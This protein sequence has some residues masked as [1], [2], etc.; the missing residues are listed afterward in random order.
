[1]L[2][3]CSSLSTQIFWQGR[4][5]RWQSSHSVERSMAAGIEERQGRQDLPNSTKYSHLLEYCGIMTKERYGPNLPLWTR[6]LGWFLEPAI[7]HG[8]W[9]P[10][11]QTECSDLQRK[12]HH[13]FTIIAQKL[14]VYCGICTC[15]LD[16]KARSCGW[17]VLI[18]SASLLKVQTIWDLCPKLFFSVADLRNGAF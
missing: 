13:Y 18:S 15:R 6:D 11:S 16:N 12:E 8:P 14:Q 2:Q 4:P 10:P 7:S 1:M 17:F 9:D 5:Q 3:Y